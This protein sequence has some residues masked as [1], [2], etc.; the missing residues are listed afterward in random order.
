MLCFLLCCVFSQE[1]DQKRKNHEC[2]G[3]GN[4][5]PYK[6]MLVSAT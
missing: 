2:D 5:I 1:Q 3:L 6:M 4:L